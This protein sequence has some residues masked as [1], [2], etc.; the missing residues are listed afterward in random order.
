MEIL[1][2]TAQIG[3]PSTWMGSHFTGDVF[4]YSLNLSDSRSLV[5]QDSRDFFQN[6]FFEVILTDILQVFTFL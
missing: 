4:P 2:G 5:A 3:E 1:T 6:N